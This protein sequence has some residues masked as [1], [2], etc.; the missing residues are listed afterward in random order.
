MVLLFHSCYALCWVLFSPPSVH[1]SRRTLL[2]SLR[3]PSPQ[4]P[5]ALPLPPS[6]TSTLVAAVRWCRPPRRAGAFPPSTAPLLH[7]SVGPSAWRAPSP[8]GVPLLQH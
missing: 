2:G 1:Y 6:S 5:L 7:R 3:S 8:S 4:G